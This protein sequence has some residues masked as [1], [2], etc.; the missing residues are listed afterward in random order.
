MTSFTVSRVFSFPASQS[1]LTPPR[2]L[3]PLLREDCSP[4]LHLPRRTV[5]PPLP[6]TQAP[7]P[8][9]HVAS[10]PPIL[11]PLVPTV[12]PSS[13][14]NQPSSAALPP[15]F[16]SQYPPQNHNPISPSPS[17]LPL[18]APRNHPRRCPTPANHA[19][20]THSFPHSHQPFQIALSHENTAKPHYASAAS[21]PH[22]RI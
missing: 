11:R 4:L 16:I 20:A 22:A 8:M 17:L 5:T 9:S 21:Y 10:P 19:D 3:V 14:R 18:P 1:P 15:N 7:T 13:T 6:T 2:L 12:I